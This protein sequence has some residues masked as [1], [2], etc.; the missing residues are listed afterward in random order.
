M[1]NALTPS[2]KLKLE[3]SLSISRDISENIE[4]C[5]GERE[6]ERRKG[7]GVKRNE[8]VGGGCQYVM[9][10]TVVMIKQPCARRPNQGLFRRAHFRKWI[11][12]THRHWT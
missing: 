4:E 7:N 3:N 8:G 10:V 5:S 9:Q 11:N 2:I 1:H 12:I 6:R